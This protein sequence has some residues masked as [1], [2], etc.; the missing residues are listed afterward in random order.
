M[1][2]AMTHGLTPAQ[3][4]D[5]DSRLARRIIRAH[6]AAFVRCA[7]NGDLHLLFDP[8]TE[9]TALLPVPERDLLTALLLALRVA[10]VVAA[11]FGIA[12]LCRTDR[13]SALILVSTIVYFLILSAGPEG[14]FLSIRFRAP[15]IGAESTAAA[16]AIAR[17]WERHAAR[18]RKP[19]AASAAIVAS[20]AANPR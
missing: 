3:A 11:S 5:V 9:L 17:L 7:V 12:I 2:A 14:N 16:F 19:A 8:D 13:P 4:A 10:M 15:V 20:D 6:S 1:H 18:A